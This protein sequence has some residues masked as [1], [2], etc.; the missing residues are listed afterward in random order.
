M[1]VY[2][3]DWWEESFLDK[4]MS[5]SLMWGHY[6]LISCHFSL[7]FWK[8]ME[9]LGQTDEDQLIEYAIQLSIQDTC[10]LPLLRQIERYV[11][12][13]ILLYIYNAKIKECLIVNTYRFYYIITSL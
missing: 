13:T 4:H 1:I 12:T 8:V 9:A 7:L 3:M 10:K 6:L 5:T 2:E 11:V